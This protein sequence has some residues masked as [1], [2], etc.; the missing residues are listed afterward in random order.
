MALRNG[1]LLLALSTSL[2]TGG[3]RAELPDDVKRALAMRDYDQ[4]ALWLD[5]NRT[6]PEA[7]FELAKL[8]RQGRGV[9]VDESAALELLKFAAEAGH[10]EAQYLTGRYYAQA[11]ELDEA[12]LWMSRAAAAGHR[13]AAQW[14]PPR[15][16]ERTVDVFNR[17]RSDEPPPARIERADAHGMD[18]SGRTPL[19]LAADH[20][21]LAW[22]RVLLA[23]GAPVDTSDQHGVTALHRAALRSNAEIVRRLLEADADPNLIDENGNTAL[24]LA[25][26]GESVAVIMALRE[27]GADSTARNSAGWSAVDLARRSGDEQIMRL[28]GLSVATAASNDATSFDPDSLLRRL[29]DAALKEDLDRVEGLVAQP[30]FDPGMPELTDLLIMLAETG[31]SGSLLLML[32]AGVPPDEK[33]ARRRTALLAAA[34]SAQAECIEALIGHG[35][36]ARM[37]DAQGRTGLILAS[38]SGSAAAVDVLMDAGAEPGAADLQGR[39]ALWWATRSGNETLALRLLSRGVPVRTDQEGTG[40]LHLAASE[41]LVDLLEALVLSVPVDE[42]TG[43][44]H[45]ALML[46]ARAGSHEVVS[47]LIEAGAEV[48]LRSPAG[49]TALIIA[50]R[51]AHLEVARVL[52][53]NGANPET[54]NDRF[55]SA[56]SIAM[57]LADERWQALMEAH[58]RDLL[59]LLGTRITPGVASGS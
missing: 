56:S 25:V 34:A 4:A 46:A 20:D 59:D 32:E 12:A 53:E 3:V 52:L 38:R 23:A 10:S 49:D 15:P 35:A 21:D 22:V 40:P 42:V 17:I 28:L 57:D 31:A 51:E 54:R 26:A 48:G 2:C 47:S 6:D 44:G 16:H 1:L 37:R 36:D 24:H 45:S 43:D 19:M 9:E 14:T 29:S 33:D 8:Y 27:S 30:K 50:A 55:E 58:R 11:G 7:A 13:R 39:N 41:N 5:A 18:P